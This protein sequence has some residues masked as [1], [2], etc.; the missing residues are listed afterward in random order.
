MSKKDLSEINI[1]Y[2]INGEKEIKIF[3]VIFVQNNKNICKMIID[4]KDYELTNIY[5]IQRNNNNKL[6]IK[7]KGINNITNLSCMFYGCTSL[8]SLPDISKWNTN[9]VTNMSY[10]FAECSSLLSI[11]DISKLNTNNV[12]EMSY[13]F[14]G[15]SSLLSLP[16]ISKWNINKVTNMNEMFGGCSSL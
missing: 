7:L 4:D 12:T 14:L 2:D 6:K 8:S 13:M 9:K 3:G 16:D 10:M 15:C 1:I 5:K 11:P